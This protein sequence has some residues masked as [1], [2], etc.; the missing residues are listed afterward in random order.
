MEI[1]TNLRPLVLYFGSPPS[2]RLFPHIHVLTSLLLRT[3]ERP[4]ANLQGSHLCGPLS[5]FLLLA[6]L[7]GNSLKAIGWPYVICFSSFRIHYFLQ[8]DIS[9][10]NTMISYILSMFVIILCSRVNHSLVI[11]SWLE[12]KSEKCF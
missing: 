6:S 3:G 8:L 1:G 5:E 10:L 12:R 9:V 4:S 11:P 7:H 2:L